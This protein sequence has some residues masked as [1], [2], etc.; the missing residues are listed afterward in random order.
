METGLTGTL[1]LIIGPSGV[2]KGT[3]LSQIKKDFS[4]D[5]RF[6]F[7]ITATTRHPR[8]GEKNGKDYFFLNKEEFEAGIKDG[9][10]LEHALVHGSNY[11]GLPKGQ[12]INALK[13]GE[14]VIRELDIQG[15]WNL[16]KIIPSENLFSIFLLPPSIEALRERIISRAPVMESELTRRLNSAKK[17]ISHAKECDK[18]LVSE[19][20]KIDEL[21]TAM[22]NVFF[23]QI[24]K[25]ELL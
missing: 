21:T 23:Q 22:K 18:L 7:P 14:N 20:G 13:K 3:V 2:G 17:E 6:V 8:P 10:F 25:K 11:Y 19:E 16:K 5:D 9:N 1:F 4:E 15:L 12:V 24:A